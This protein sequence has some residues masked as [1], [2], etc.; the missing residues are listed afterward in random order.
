M[1]RRL[2]Y[3]TMISPENNYKTSTQDSIESSTQ[4]NTQQI[5]Q[6]NNQASTSSKVKPLFQPAQ[7]SSTDFCP[8][9]NNSNNSNDSNDYIKHEEAYLMKELEQCQQ[10][11]KQI[12]A[13]L[14][15]I[16]SV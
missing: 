4:P 16:R 3:R 9:T 11:I 2:Q 1:Q 7:K 6:L 15:I 13:R 5:S 12:M 8:I 10:R 14:D